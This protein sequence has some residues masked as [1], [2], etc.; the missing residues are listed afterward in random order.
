MHPPIT[1]SKKG[2]D[3]QNPRKNFSYAGAKGQELNS[4]SAQDKPIWST[5]ARPTQLLPEGDWTV[6][7]ILA[8]RGFGKT[9]TGAEAV[10]QWIRTQKCQSVAL[11][12]ETEDEVRR[13]MIEGESGLLTISPDDERPKY[14]ICKGELL[15]P[16]GAKG[17]IYTAENYEKLRGAQF[18]GAWVDELAKFR[19]A[20]QVWDQMMFGLRLGAHPQV[21]V[22]TTP[23]PLAL[24]ETLMNDAT[25][26]LTR[27]STYDNKD[28]LS[29]VFV[30]Q[31]L[32]T[33]EG[34]R[35]GAQEI[36]AE[37]L[38]DRVG[39]LWARDLIIYG[40]PSSVLINKK[41]SQTS[42]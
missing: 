8:G 22:T 29:P 27:G 35:L 28:N 18:D 17:L 12:G 20:Q 33:Y 1:Y 31:I 23:R 2:G 42:N 21:V 41:T 40:M 19:N 24:L 30:N 3:L 11:I 39:A 37:L 15:W 34:T 16:C 14:T 6:W 13:V 4:P 38:L 9:R 32:K 25:T 36:H 5:L 7:L 26:H 10:L